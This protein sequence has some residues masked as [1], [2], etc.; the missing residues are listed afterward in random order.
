MT[1][2]RWSRP[3]DYRKVNAVLRYSAGE[4]LNALSITAMGYQGK[5]N[6]TDQIPERAV[7]R[8]D[9]GRFDAIDPT[10]GGNTYRF[11][12]SLDW[13]RTR[14]N[15]STK[16]TAYGIAY[17]L[18]LFSNF[19]Y[20]LDDPVHGDQFR[21]ADHRFVSGAAVS[22][23]RLGTWD[24]HAVQNTFGV[25]LRNDDITT[26][27]LFHTERRHLLDIVR[28]DKVL[29]TSGAVYAQNDLQW[30]RWLRTLAGVR[31][32]GYRFDVDAGNPLN[33]GIARAGLVSPKAGVIVGPFKGTELYA[34]AGYG[35]HSNDGRGSTITV[36]PLSGE[37]ADKVTSLVRANGAEAGI[38]TVAIPHLQSTLTWWSLD[39]A[40]ELVFSGDAGTTNAGRPS[41]RSGVE[42]AN[43]Y[44]PRRWLT[45]DLDLAVS[46]ARFT[47]PDPSG[48]R[49]PGS[50]ETVA[51]AAA[52]V[53]SWRKI[54]G[55][56]RL[57]YFG[58]R[59]LVEDNSI[60]SRATTLINLNGAYR[61]TRGVKIA[62]D[63]FNLFDARQSDI[64]YYY[65]SRLPGEPIDGTG[66]VHFHPTSPRT[67]RV[68]LVVGF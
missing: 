48:S 53:D 67:A 24:S 10:D 55:S 30:T 17:D 45:L 57:R 52:T 63:V 11:S 64:D 44:S 6:S 56:M 14:G 42:F 50:V 19:T 7:Q 9:L 28:E 65:V 58:P 12:G 39:L 46:R 66:D 35:F 8:A 62:I 51:S 26:V 37:P 3:D 54:S 68:N 41:R 31:A 38:R 21:Q 16:V 15:A 59:P 40:S 22:H 2:A 4:P 47:D 49:I 23:R 25:Q 32:D 61:L 1:T 43:Y 60:R 20:F 13:Q 29:Q 27:G 18:D 34:N 33:G 5:W 36:D